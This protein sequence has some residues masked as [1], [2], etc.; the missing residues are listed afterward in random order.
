MT[1]RSGQFL[2]TAAVECIVYVS[3]TYCISCIKFFEFWYKDDDIE[4]ALEAFQRS[5]RKSVARA[6]RELGV[7]KMTVW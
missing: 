5:P 2:S 1:R 6:S 7:A 4:R 3:A